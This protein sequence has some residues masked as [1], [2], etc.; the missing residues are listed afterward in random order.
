MR[1]Q[2]LMVYIDSEK[3]ASK[4]K[5]TNS[6]VKGFGLRRT[7]FASQL[8]TGEILHCRKI[9]KPLSNNQYMLKPA[10]NQIHSN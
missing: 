8:E 5:V 1:N 10:L 3:S 9:T 4:R 7:R 6:F 2:K